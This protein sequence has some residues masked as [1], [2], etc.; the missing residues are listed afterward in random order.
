MDK[1]VII[2]GAS[3]GIGLAAARRLAAGGDH[4]VI[5][6]RDRQRLRAA[7]EEVRDA[8]GGRAPDCYR[9]DF[10][11]LDDVR[12][13]GGKLR[14]AYDRVDV[15]ASN[16][17]AA[18]RQCVTTT[19]GFDLAMQVNHL[20]GFL[21]SHLLRDCMAAASTARLITTS[22][23]VERRTVLD[24]GSSRSHRATPP[25]SRSGYPAAPPLGRRY[26]PHSRLPS[27][28]R[29]S[30]PCAATKLPWRSTREP[31]PR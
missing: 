31:D 22:S 23:L 7:A 29:S 17:G 1:V 19:D 14:A 18:P 4:V 3:S 25:R 13:L 15:L 24:A 30:P 16:A 10:A 20:A 28:Q 21:L 27:E 26:W 5:V 11:R 8:A 9:A 6:G 12:E 2:T